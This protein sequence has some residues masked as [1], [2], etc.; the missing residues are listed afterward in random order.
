M[1]INSDTLSAALQQGGQLVTCYDEVWDRLWQQT[2]V[3]AAVLELCRL[4]LAALH[5]AVADTRLR[6]LAVG[7]EKIDAV[8]A[9]RY[10]ASLFDG[11]ELAALELAEIYAQDP[12]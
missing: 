5:G 1:N 2:H 12:A 10:G 6:K 4:R 9:G 3:P 8:L 11:M 7:E